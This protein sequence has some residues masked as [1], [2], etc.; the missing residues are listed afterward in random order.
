MAAAAAN[1]ADADIAA[2]AAVA[3]VAAVAAAGVAYAAE[4]RKDAV[5]PARVVEGSA[6]AEPT[7]IRAPVR[8]RSLVLPGGSLRRKATAESDSDR[9]GAKAQPVAAE[10]R[11]AL[12]VTSINPNQRITRCLPCEKS[13]PTAA[14]SEPSG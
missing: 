8:P 3:V 1:Q 14:F 7:P 12:S 2:A 10:D 13:L 4:R 9:R 5:G 6:G 11:T